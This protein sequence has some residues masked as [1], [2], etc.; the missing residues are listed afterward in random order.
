MNR[1]SLDV[2]ASVAVK[3]RSQKPEREGA[4][5]IE[6]SGRLLIDTL[7]VR[8]Q[9]HCEVLVLKAM[10]GEGSKGSSRYAEKSPQG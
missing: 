6:Q 4:L 10:S 5:G 9:G 3:G 7:K 1:A 2:V 8:Y